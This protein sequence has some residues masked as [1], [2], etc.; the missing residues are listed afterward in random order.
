[1]NRDKIHE[2]GKFIDDECR[3]VYRYKCRWIFYKGEPLIVCTMNRPRRLNINA[4]RRM[5]SSSIQT[6]ILSSL[7]RHKDSQSAYLN[8]LAY[9]N[10][11]P[12]RF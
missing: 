12:R 10:T 8:K 11:L 9:I 5:R 1:M 4:C 7:S 2:T 3:N 6:S